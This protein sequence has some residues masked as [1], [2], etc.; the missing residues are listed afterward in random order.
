MVIF[1]YKQFYVCNLGG[2]TCAKCKDV[3]LGRNLNLEYTLKQLPTA[4][5]NAL[6]DY[7]R[8]IKHCRSEQSLDLAYLKKL[9]AA[10][11]KESKGSG[12]T[13]ESLDNTINISDKDENKQDKSDDVASRSSSSIVCSLQKTSC[14]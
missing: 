3:L 8:P 5:L 13:N 2:F 4:S 12:D 6:A 1:L 11:S 7:S 14:R 9:E 10:R